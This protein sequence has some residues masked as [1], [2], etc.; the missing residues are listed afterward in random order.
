MIACFVPEHNSE[1]LHQP[2]FMRSSLHWRV[3]RTVMWLVLHT[4]ANTGAVAAA[5]VCAQAA[6]STVAASGTDQLYSQDPALDTLIDRWL[7][8][9]HASTSAPA[10]NGNGNGRGGSSKRQQRQPDQQV[11]ADWEALLGPVTVTLTA[12]ATLEVSTPAAADG[13]TPC[14]Q[15]PV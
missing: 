13:C 14:M 6:S 1:L 4:Q 9:K 11:Q 2:A 15:L 3:R 10:S 7:S 5:A 12:L 8:H